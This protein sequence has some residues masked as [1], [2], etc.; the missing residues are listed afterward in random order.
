MT[1]YGYDLGGYHRAITTAVPEAQLWFDRGMVWCYAY[2]HEEAV[3]CFER[4][5]AADPECAIAWWG[6][7]Y[8]AG[9]N[10]NK[11]WKAFDPV[12]LQRSLETAWTATE[13][14]L[15][16]RDHA[17]AVERALIE[18][19]AERYRSA[20][21][22][23]V[24]PVWN[25]GYAAAMRAVYREQPDDHDVAA[26]F[27][28]AIMNRTPWQLWE[29]RTGRPAEGADTAEAIEVLERSL[30]QPGG[31]DHPGL[32]HMYVHLMEMSPHP[33]RALRAAD[34]LRTAVPD[35]GHLVHMP[36]HIDVL[37]GLYKN[38][39]DW[40]ERAV[41]ADRKYVKREG[42]RNFY[43]LYRAHNYHFIVYG[44]MFLGQYRTAIDAAERMVENLPE[45]LLRV[46]S[47]PMADWLEGFVPMKQHVLIRFGKWEEIIG[48][49]L[50]ADPVLYSTT[51][52]MI[53]Y[54]KAV[55]HAALG[56]VG[57][58]DREAE[59]FEAAV[60]LVPPS[61][62]V[63]N[64]TCL[65]ILAVAAE[66]M[67]GEIAYRKGE[68]DAAFA[69]LRRS[70]ELDDSLP[71]DEPWGWMQPT[72]HALGALLIEQGRVEEAEAVYRADLGLDRTIPRACLHPENVWS[73]H[74]FHECLMRLGKF[75]EANLIK[76][77]LDLALAW[78]DV[79][80]KSSCFCRMRNAA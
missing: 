41:A 2:N 21:P 66:M 72:R 9:P 23:E 57:E 14:A 40:N 5:A 28:E 77:R 33:E 7:A 4:A 34:R 51:T 62:G 16:L 18:P 3:R 29:I 71:Y 52:A 74:G 58:A 47:P 27:A 70:V 61:R 35:A 39:C 59:R 10:Y 15:A 64:N 67:K 1:V 17:S 38:V 78:A 6:V 48:Q 46:E 55:A 49:E 80:I 20:D 44:A 65:D 25:D 26:L 63:F 56:D 32:L 24:T 69:H 54:A 22:A 50:P 76:G 37:C 68:F 31:M 12:D 8:A 11:Q 75:T 36:T 42:A 43:S 19:L 79:P 73:L 13:K 60:A 30:A 53:H 45:E